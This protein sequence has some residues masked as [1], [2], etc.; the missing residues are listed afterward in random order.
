[1]DLRRGPEVTER[2]I[3]RRAAE[4]EHPALRE[5]RKDMA[6][7]ATAKG[8]W[9]APTLAARGVLQEDRPVRNSMM[10]TH[11]VLVD[12]PEQPPTNGVIEPDGS[13][14]R[15]RT[16]R[17]DEYRSMA[18]LEQGLL[19]DFPARVDATNEPPPDDPMPSR[20]R[21]GATTEDED[22]E[23]MESEGGRV[24]L[25]HRPVDR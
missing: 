17:T 10:S 13:A 1:M 3:A 25:P 11:E 9:L 7:C 23:R 14:A 24:A 4:A 22:G 21:Q 19:R 20:V 18:E 2:G 8:R 15:A 6:R 12:E 16:M 5:D